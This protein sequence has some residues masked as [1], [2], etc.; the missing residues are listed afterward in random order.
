[1]AVRNFYIESNI[2]GRET[3][4]SGGPRNK[5]DGM[6]TKLYQ[7]CC[8]EIVEALKIVCKEVNGDLITTVYADGVKI[9]ERIT[10]RD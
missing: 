7:R 9:H 1:M 8:G 5:Q 6:T 2:D 4:L 10:K 3:L